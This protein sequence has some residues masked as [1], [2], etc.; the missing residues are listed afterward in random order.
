MALLTCVVFVL[1]LQLGVGGAT[2]TDYVDD[3]VTVFAALLA[4]VLCVRARARVRAG[5]ELQQKQ[6]STEPQQ[7]QPSTEPQQK[8]PSTEPQQ[9]QPSTELQQKQPSTEPQ[10]KQMARFWTLLACATACWTLAEVIWAVYDLILGENVPVPSWADIGYL[11]AIPLSVAA[12]LAHPAAHGTSTRKARTVFDGL[13]VATALLFLS[14]TLLLGP[15]WRSTDLTTAGGLVSLAYPFGD[16]V[17]V[18]FIVLVVRNMTSGSRLSLWALLGGL[19]A[20]ALSDSF[21]TYLTELTTYSTGSA[22]DTGWVVAYL[23]IALSAYFFD[24]ADAPV[25]APAPA[26]ADDP[27]PAPTLVALISPLLPVLLALTVAGVQLKLGHHLDRAAWIMAFG[28][29]ALVLV[30]QA[31][32]VLELLAPHPG[33]DA[34]LMD[35]LALAALG[36]SAANSSDTLR[37]APHAGSGP[38]QPVVTPAVHHRYEEL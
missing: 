8:Q 25:P 12:L 11:S 28:L 23:G 6:P 35:R 10:Q 36:G 21:Y 22:I 15:L 14:W 1:W 16:I 18:F 38:A 24:P 2:V 5:T 34:R 19:L 26:F 7:K 20:M 31:L 9:K 17:I 4:T 37:P 30:R 13:V 27:P 33:S 32:L 29:I 3:L